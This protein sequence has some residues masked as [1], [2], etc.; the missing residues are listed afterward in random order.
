MA[1]QDELRESMKKA[2]AALRDADVPFILAGSMAC[3]ARGGPV[4]QHDVDFMVKPEDADRA[5]KALEEAGLR[6]ERPPEGWL[7]KAW[8]GDVLV[9]LIWSPSGMEIT[10]EV[11][12]RADALNV[13]AVTMRVMRLEDVIVTK[14]AALREHELDYERILEISRSLR[15][16]IVW[17]EVRREAP[18]NPYVRAFFTMIEGLGIAPPSEAHTAATP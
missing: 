17:D 16:L 3:W 12:A 14:L 6:I 5:V 11:F 4:S 18:D 13:H 9:D 8:D 15:E 10:D 1:T 7:F 2:A